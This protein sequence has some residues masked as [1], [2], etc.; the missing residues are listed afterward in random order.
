MKLVKQS[1]LHGKEQ[2]E[3]LSDGGSATGASPPS[4]ARTSAG[5]Y[6]ERKTPESPPPGPTPFASQWSRSPP[7]L[8]PGT[9]SPDQ[10]IRSPTKGSTS[11]LF[12]F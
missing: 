11:F 5:K 7:A 6:E 4:T 12:D 10:L 3:G 2:A 8:L 1:E 9:P